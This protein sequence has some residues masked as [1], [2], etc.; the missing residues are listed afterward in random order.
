MRYIS[1][2]L[3]IALSQE[4]KTDYQLFINKKLTYTDTRYHSLANNYTATVMH[5]CMAM[6]IALVVQAIHFLS[7]SMDWHVSM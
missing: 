7:A 3:F 6:Y 1:H 5:L 2:H 4:I